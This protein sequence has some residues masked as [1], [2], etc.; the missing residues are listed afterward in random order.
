M[1]AGQTVSLT[2][3]GGKLALDNMAG[4]HAKIS[5]LTHAA[6]LIDLSGFTFSDGPTVAWT[7]AGT[8]G[9]L[10][11]TDGAKV[12]KLTLIGTY[13]TS[14]FHLADDTHGGTFVNDTQPAAARFA[15]AA[16]G[17]SGDGG[18]AANSPL[19]PRE[20]RAGDAPVAAAMSGR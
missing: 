11:V 3:S 18:G 9:T 19:H 15:Q 12:A 13:A 17:V 7:Q 20:L 6:Q 2:G 1:A 4:F 10:T 8:S 16:A 14:D 5:G